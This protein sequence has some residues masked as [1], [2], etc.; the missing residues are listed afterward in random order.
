MNCYYK[1]IEPVL[2][3]DDN[4]SLQEYSIHDNELLHLSVQLNLL[5]KVPCCRCS[6]IYI[7][8]DYT[9]KHI[10]EKKQ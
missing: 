5:L 6:T 10:Q 1:Y 2:L 7:F 3:D 4:K 9:L 8:T